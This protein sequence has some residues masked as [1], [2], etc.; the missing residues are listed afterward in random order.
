MGILSIINASLKMHQDNQNLDKLQSLVTLS[1]KISALVHETQKERGASAGFIGSHGQKFVQK[2]PNQ[3]KN[4]D[5]KLKEYRDY[6]ATLDEASLSPEINQELTTLSQA[7]ENLLSS[8]ANFLKSKERAGVEK[9][10]ELVAKIENIQTVSRENKQA[11]DGVD[12]VAKELTEKSKFL[13]KTLEKF[14]V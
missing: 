2:L 14:T 5:Q 8:Y 1:S 11:S 6:I 10:K 13:N 4:T 12:K 3:R 7:L 9:T